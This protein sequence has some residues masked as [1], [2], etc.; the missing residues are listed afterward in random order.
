MYKKC[1]LIVLFF[2]ALISSDCADKNKK[3]ENQPQTKIEKQLLNYADV[4][5]NTNLDVLSANQRKMLPYLFEA[6][7]LID[8]LYWIQTYGKKEQLFETI[9]D[10]NTLKYVNINYGPWDRLNGNEPFVEGVGKKPDG[11]NF[12][13][14]DMSYQEFEEFGDLE[15]YSSYTLLRRNEIGGLQTI[16]YY[17]AYDEKLQTIADLMMKAA[18]LTDNGDLKNYLQLR[19]KALITDKYFDSDLAWMKMKDNVVDFI[20]GPIDEND[21]RLFWSK[22]SYQSMVLIKDKDWSKNLEKYALLLPYLQKNLPVDAKYITELPKGFSDIMVYDVIYCT[23]CWNAGSKK[24]AFNLP[25]D[26]QVQQQVGSRKLQFRNV[27]EAKFEKILKPMSNLLI[28]PDQHKHVTFNAFFENT[29]FYE[30]GSS[31]GIKETIKNQPVRDALK[32]YYNVIEESKNDILSLFFITKLYDMGELNSG[33]LM[34]NYVTY[35]A[36]IFRSVRFG[37]SNDQGVANMIRFNYFQDAGA[38]SYDNKTNTY[39]I[40]FEKMKQAMN[41]LA[42]TILVIQ[43]EGNYEE[44][45]KLITE[46]GFIRDELLNDLYRVQKE[47]I[48]KDVVFIQGLL[49]LGLP[50]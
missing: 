11:A 34:D 16:P 28:N 12:Y 47:R 39:T 27:M 24:I 14:A 45:K 26:G 31:L 36:D 42:N 48:P 23:G 21:D 20:V 32:E 43:G 15:K 1:A 25:R 6:A 37:I 46:K 9:T 49:E 10:E 19:A 13:P 38:F 2:V 29:M 3:K 8:D 7:K 4:K 22:A 33:T 17:K 50:E 40:H 18:E 44:A 30:V 41:S 5:L 35:M